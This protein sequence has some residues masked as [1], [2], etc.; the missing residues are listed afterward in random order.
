MCQHRVPFQ[1]SSDTGPSHSNKSNTPVTNV[2]PDSITKIWPR[3]SVA[4]LRV[5]ML[6]FK[7][8]GRS[9]M[10]AAHSGLMMRAFEPFTGLRAERQRGR[11]AERHGGK[12]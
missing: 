11:E 9:K 1:R 6:F 4:K 12:G 2:E 5:S 7:P 8:D 3:F 10:S